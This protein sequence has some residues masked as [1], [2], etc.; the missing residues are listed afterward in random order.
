MTGTLQIQK[1]VTALKA[2]AESTR[3]RILLLLAAGELNVKDL[4]QILGQS[5]PRISRH[6]KLLAEAGLIERFRQGS[7]V[8]FHVSDRS[9]GGKLVRRLLDTVDS[10]DPVLRRDSER[11]EALK[12]EREAAAQAYFRTHAADWDRIRALYVSESAVEAAVVSALAGPPIKLLVDLGTGTGRILEVLAGRYERGLGLDVN[13]SMLA[14]ARSKLKTAGLAHAEV[15]HGDVYNVALPDGAADAVVI[16]QVLHYL[17]EP[18]HAVR[19]AARILAPG[20]RLLIVDFAP[21]DIEALRDEQAHERLGFESEQVAGWLKE[22]GLGSPDI[23]SL[24]PETHDDRQQLTVSIWTARKP[25]AAAAARQS[26]N[27]EWIGS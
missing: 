13:Q 26:Q 6:L 11:A 27:L 22:A 1:L 8:Y 9:D 24:A 18:A 5:Q 25:D 15:R 2:A 21:H 12:R 16:H 14:Y 19:E 20:G 7:W 23:L 4:T 3:L 17:S 10:H